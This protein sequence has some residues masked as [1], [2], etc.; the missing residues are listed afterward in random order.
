MSPVRYLDHPL[1]R[2]CYLFGWRYHHGMAGMS[3]V[4]AAL[5]P[6]PLLLRVGMAAVGGALVGDD[7][8]DFPWTDA[9]NH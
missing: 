8:R 4:A 9:H 6:L 5:L 3:L 1:G 7:W 2:R